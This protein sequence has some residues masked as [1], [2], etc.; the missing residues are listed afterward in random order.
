[1]V[2]TL[3]SELDVVQQHGFCSCS[4][5]QGRQMAAMLAAHGSGGIE[6]MA[7]LCASEEGSAGVPVEVER[8]QVY[9]P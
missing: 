4:G 9:R 6:D 2:R 3:Q 7:G 1:V 5:L 8:E